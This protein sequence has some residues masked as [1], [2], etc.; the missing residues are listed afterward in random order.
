MKVLQE[1]MVFNADARI[2]SE[3]LPD[4]TQIQST[5]TSP[6]YFDMK[7]YGVEGQVGYGQDYETY[8]DDLQNIFKQVFRYTRKDG[9]LWIVI[10]TFKRNNTVVPLPFDL[11]SRLQQVGWLLQD[12]I[13]WKK[14]KTVPWSN[15]GFTQRKFEYVLLFVKSPQ[16]KYNKDKVR[17][18]DTRQL[19]KWWIK[20]P[21]RYNPRGKALDEIW[22]YPIPVQGSWGDKYIRHFCPLPKDMVSNMIQIGTDEGDLVFDP[23]AGSGTV[24]TQAAYMNRKYLGIELNKSYIKQFEQYLHKTY[25]YGKSEY[26]KMTQNPD[27]NDF[28][29]QIL[30][31][32]ALKYG[33]LLVRKLE[34]ATGQ[35][36]K[37][38]VNRDEKKI[39]SKSV[40]KL[41]FVNSSSLKVEDVI[42]SLISKAPLSKFEIE[43][44]ITFISNISLENTLY[45][46]SITNSYSYMRDVTVDD[47]RVKVL[48][49][50]MVDFKESDYE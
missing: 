24:L 35:D 3:V 13:I 5:I 27:Q 29:T 32:R 9:T 22:E 15:S 26:E 47:P 34:E 36:F 6:P 48:S 11:S 42:S 49:P 38:I 16:Y 18:Y 2:M 40:V 1:N 43:P 4:S 50:I 17:V 46:Y 37:V 21:E 8:L 19:K 39:N 10:D 25:S 20:Y 14:D 41:S 28:E 33:R 23:F 44:R 45:C 12:I 7:D 31:L 30:N